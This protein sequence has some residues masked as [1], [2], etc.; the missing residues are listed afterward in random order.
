MGK[1]LNAEHSQHEDAY[2][3][4]D[5]PG[6]DSIHSLPTKGPRA[7]KFNG[8]I[9]SPSFEPSILARRKMWVSKDEPA[10][11]LVCHSWVT[12]GRIQFFNDSTHALA[13]QTV[14][15]KDIE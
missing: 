6:C 2:Y 11:E 12:D 4:F 3:E 7:W 15:M 13:G 8:N 1:K 10:I 9:E 14:E 5:C